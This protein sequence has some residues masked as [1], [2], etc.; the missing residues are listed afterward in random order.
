MTLG[1]K[2]GIDLLSLL[3]S[4]LIIPCNRK[5]GGEHC[6]CSWSLKHTLQLTPECQQVG[7][8]ALLG[9]LCHSGSVQSS[10]R[11][12][13]SWGGCHCSLDELAGLQHPSCT[14]FHM[15]CCPSCHTM[16]LLAA[17]LVTSTPQGLLLYIVGPWLLLLLTPEKSHQRKLQGPGSS[18]HI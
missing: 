16:P 8:G 7:P 13:K 2:S 5:D 18:T 14:L 11:P 17:L 1:W 9:Q 4:S 15:N 6:L 3:V 12:W 10:E